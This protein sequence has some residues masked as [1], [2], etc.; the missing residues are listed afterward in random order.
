MTATSE[1]F[2]ATR[3]YMKKRVEL[4]CI[5]YDLTDI[6]EKEMSKERLVIK[7]N[8]SSKDLS[9]SKLLNIAKGAADDLK[10]LSPCQAY[11]ESV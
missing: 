9:I 6:R 11:G 2:E 8:G 10:S 5:L 3:T 7:E 4:N 1:I